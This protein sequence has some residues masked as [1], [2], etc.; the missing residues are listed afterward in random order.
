[1]TELFPYQKTGAAFLAERR[2]AM[3]L[4][5]PGLGKTAQAIEACNL[6]DAGTVLV[7]CPASARAHWRSEFKRFGPKHDVTV[8]SYEKV[9]ADWRQF[10]GP[11]GALVV[12]EAHYLKSYSTKRSRAIYGTPNPADWPGIARVSGHVFSLTGTPAPNHA[13]EM[14]MHMLALHP[15]SLRVADRPDMLY[16]YDAFVWQ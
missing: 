4:D 7:V 1:M 10:D 8:E 16:G 13:G 5:E 11:W 2:R 15:E 3:L 12:D 14:W 9:S 6:V